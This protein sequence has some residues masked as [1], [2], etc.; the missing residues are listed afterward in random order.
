MTMNKS[1]T[2][3]GKQTN[4][5]CTG[6][7]TSVEKAVPAAGGSVES[8][9]PAKA[10]SSTKEKTT[11]VKEVAEI[12][13]AVESV[14]MSPRDEIRARKEA[15]R[16]EE[17]SNLTFKPK[18]AVSKK[19]V[20]KPAGDASSPAPVT[21]FA[22]LSESKKKHADGD[23]TSPAP[24]AQSKPRPKATPESI[25]RLYAGSGVSKTHSAHAAVVEE[26]TAPKVKKQSAEEA[27]R[28]AARLYAQADRHK[29]LMEA[30]KNKV[31]S[32]NRDKCTFKPTLSSRH[33]AP[34]KQEG[35]LAADYTL[36]Q[37]K[38]AADRA[39]RLEEARRDREESEL[40]ECSFKPA[41]N[42][43]SPAPE[44][45]VPSSAGSVRKAP[46]PSDS[47]ECT[48]RPQLQT[49][50]HAPALPARAPGISVHERLFKSGVASLK[51]QEEQ[52]RRLQ[53]EQLEKTCTFAPKGASPTPAAKK[54]ALF[55][56]LASAKKEDLSA[57]REQLEL[58]ECTFRPQVDELAA[59][60]K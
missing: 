14:F 26:N 59:S 22:R 46:V 19:M 34:E 40:R 49:T 12:A 44:G 37:A 6:A 10:A 17:E 48:F 38:Y 36:R 58:S 51:E 27:A 29:E 7:P 53:E 41:L 43:R 33:K 15:K 1:L 56:R 16:M 24:G 23:S 52:R 20:T 55:A 50:K 28:S 21:I 57:V 5:P 30:T 35:E 2:P 8:K 31:E 39:R 3:N 42:A 11:P 9:I 18:L 25:N 13:A 32:E 60:M 4:L 54:E 45:E 47:Q